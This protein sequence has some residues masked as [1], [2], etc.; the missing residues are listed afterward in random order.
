[1]HPD[2]DLASTGHG[3][4]NIA[5]LKDLTGGAVALVPDCFHPMRPYVWIFLAYPAPNPDAFPW[6]SEVECSAED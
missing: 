4:R 1:M 2:E 3:V 6:S 5:A